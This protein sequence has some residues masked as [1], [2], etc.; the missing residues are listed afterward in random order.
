MF[1]KPLIQPRPWMLMLGFL[2]NLFIFIY[3]G[4]ENGFGCQFTDIEVSSVFNILLMALGILFT[5]LAGKLDPRFEK[6]G[7]DNFSFIA[8]VAIFVILPSM[9]IANEITPFIEGVFLPELV[10]DERFTLLN[11]L[12]NNS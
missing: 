10:C 4:I 7:G 2:A 12:K 11:Y 5:F 1:F 3:L 9:L 6:F 8:F